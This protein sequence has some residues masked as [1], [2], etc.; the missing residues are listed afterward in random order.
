MF[1]CS[2]Q[3]G[4]ASVCVQ[5]LARMDVSIEHVHSV[6]NQAVLDTYI[7]TFCLTRLTS[8]C[9]HSSLVSVSLIKALAG[10][11]RPDSELLRCI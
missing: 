7:C 5:Q 2:H 10:V 9:N 8:N 1:P 6:C 3:G 11:H 4:A